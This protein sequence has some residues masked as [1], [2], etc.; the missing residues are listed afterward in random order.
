MRRTGQDQ[1]IA[2]RGSVGSGKTEVRRLLISALVNVASSAQSK[3]ETKITKQVPASQFILESFGHSSTLAN[4]NASRF[5]CYTEL[6]YGEGYRLCGIKAL[7]Y[8]LDKSRLPKT[9]KGERNFHVFHYLLAGATKEEAG[10]LRLDTPFRYL[11]GACYPSNVHDDASK[12][13]KLKEAFKLVSLSKRAVASIYRVLAAILHLGQLEFAMDKSRNEDAAS[14][15]NHD[16]LEHIASL[17]G[18]A[19]ADLESSLNTQT[20][21]YPWKERVSFLLDPEGASLARDDLAVTLYG[22][23]FAWISEYL[24]SKLSK[25]D[26]KSFVSILDFPG[27][28]QSSSSSRTNGLDELCVNLANERIQSFLLE[29]AFESQKAEYANE[30]VSSFLPGLNTTYFSNPDGVR[31]LITKPGGLVHIIDDQAGKRGKSDSTMLNSMGKRWGQNSSFGWRASDEQQGRTGTFVVNHYDA[32][33]TYNAEG[34]LENNRST[35]SSNF[36]SLFATASSS[37]TG[38]GIGTRGSSDALVQELFS[39]EA[40]KVVDGQQ[41]GSGEKLKLRATLRVKPSMRRKGRDRAD[42]VSSEK[43]AEEEKFSEHGQDF[44]LG[45]LNGSLTVLLEALAE[46]SACQ[47]YYI[48]SSR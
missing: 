32:Q 4:N 39:S 48:G 33:V 26:F 37:F 22:L 31:I 11:S 3:K 7:P 40:A 20:K 19:P 23:L 35:V 43:A 17:L 18:V 21:L 1:S 46:V 44:I 45:S 8:H 41:T 2:L 14:V 25:E 9:A 5:G 42:S 30:E 27:T 15:L 29:M 10:H 36:I 28:Q 38:A 47:I 16:V 12:A 13:D 24:N 6:Q 34:F